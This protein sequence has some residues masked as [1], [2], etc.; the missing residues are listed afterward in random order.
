[1]RKQPDI[2]RIETAE[3]VVHGMGLRRFARRDYAKVRSYLDVLEDLE[4]KVGRMMLE[5]GGDED[6]DGA[7]D[8]PAQVDADDADD[9][10]PEELDAEEAE[11]RRAEEALAQQARTPDEQPEQPEQP[12]PVILDLPPPPPAPPVPTEQLDK[13][14]RPSAPPR[15]PR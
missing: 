7:D 11:A 1:M 12:A 13:K 15:R 5:D 3:E 4:A 6:D 14:L 8:K 2:E 9:D 10:T